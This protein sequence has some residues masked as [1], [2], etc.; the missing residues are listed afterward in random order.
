VWV[1]KAYA[2]TYGTNGFY[3]TGEDS[4]DLGAD[5]SGNGN[6]FTS[7]GLTSDDQVVD[8]PTDNYATLNP[9]DDAT[10]YTT[11]LISNGNLD[12][13]DR[14]GNAVRGNFGFKQGDGKFV[15]EVN[16]TT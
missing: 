5:Y 13:D 15:Y 10:G 12:V 1:P 11:P 16:I 4:A 8:T 3:I 7:S 9:L 6:D 14:T 2:G